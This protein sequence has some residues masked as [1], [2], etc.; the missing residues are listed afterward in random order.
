MICP[1]CGFENPEGTSYCGKCGTKH[2]AAAPVSVTKTIE[3]PTQRLPRGVVI[4]GRYQIMPS[5][6]QAEGGRISPAA[7]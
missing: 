4:G 1:N 7:K 5:L 3:T 6:A 2:G